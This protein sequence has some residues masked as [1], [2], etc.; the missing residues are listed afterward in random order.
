MTTLQKFKYLLSGCIM[1]G[2]IQ[3]TLLMMVE[4]S[5]RLRVTELDRLKL[6]YQN[7]IENKKKITITKKDEDLIFSFLYHSYMEY[8]VNTGFR[9]INFL[10]RG[11]DKKLNQSN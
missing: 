1:G 7:K 11:R 2:F 6:M 4:R 3:L 8:M 9:F 10:I 5:N